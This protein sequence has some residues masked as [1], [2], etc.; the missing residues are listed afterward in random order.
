MANH[1]MPDIRSAKIS[2]AAALALLSAELGYPT[3]SSEMENRMDRIIAD[4]DHAVFVA[5]DRAPIGWIHTCLIVSLEGGR[6]TEILGLVVTRSHRG[7]GIGAKLIARAEHW[8]AEK[9]CF[10]IRVRTNIVRTEARAFYKKLGYDSKKTQEV[11]DKILR[12]SD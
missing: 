8:A 10:R 7:S 12:Q 1:G 3:T 9:G 6:Y 2:D 11:F 4:Q 5:E